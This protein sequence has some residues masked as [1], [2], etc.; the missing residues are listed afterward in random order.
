LLCYVILRFIA[1]TSKWK[2]TFARLFT[3]IRGVIWSR[4][5]LQSLLDFCCGTEQERPR[6]IMLPQQLYLPL[7]VD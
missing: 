1:F 5:H 7:F 2:G 6:V 4:L 3:T